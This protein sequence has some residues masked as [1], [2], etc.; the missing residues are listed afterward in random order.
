[1]PNQELK[2]GWKN[3]KKGQKGR[4]NLN[5]IK[6]LDKKEIEN[7][8]KIKGK[9]RGV[10]FQTDGRYIL[11]KMG[12]EG[13]EKLEKR[14]KEL[15][16]TIDYRGAKTMEWYPVGLRAISLLL[17]KDVFGWGDKEIREIGKTAPKISFIV[18]FLFKLFLSPK[19][20]AE[21]VPQYWKE[22]YRNIGELEAI[23]V[24]EEKK[25]IVLHLRNFNVHPIF[26]TYLSGYFETVMALTR[27]SGKA[28]CQETKCV[29]KDNTPYHEFLLTWE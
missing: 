26:C 4:K 11:E 2:R 18:K 27:K 10:V 9:I 23:K 16:L 28:T 19:K 15:N 1:L 13:L 22:H 14:A 6:M 7:L 17:I 12:E 29:F 24:D 5:S 21:E 3:K 8:M 20:L 25:E